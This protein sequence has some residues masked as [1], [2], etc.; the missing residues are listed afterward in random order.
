MTWCKLGAYPALEL[1]VAKGLD[2]AVLQRGRCQASDII[3]LFRLQKKR[4]KHKLRARSVVS[5]NVH[6]VA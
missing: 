4:S 2:G 6:N 1:V 5:G 3:F